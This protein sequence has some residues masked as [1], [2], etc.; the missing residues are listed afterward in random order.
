VSEQ[1]FDP[2]AQHPPVTAA[3]LYDLLPIILSPDP[4]LVRTEEQIEAYR[5]SITQPPISPAL[6]WDSYVMGLRDGLRWVLQ[7]GGV[8][9]ASLAEERYYAAEFAREDAA[10]ATPAGGEERG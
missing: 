10:A 1:A 3:D 5:R 9:A 6:P 4:E 2:D 7:D 8:L